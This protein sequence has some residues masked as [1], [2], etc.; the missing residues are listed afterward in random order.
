VALAQIG[1]FSFILANLGRELTFRGEPL[2][3]DAA[4]HTIIAAAIVSITIN[5]ALYRL[6]DA[7]EHRA[8]RSPRLWK[9]LSGRTSALTSQAG[10]EDQPENGGQ[11]IVV[12][13]GPVGRTLVRLL[14]ENDIQP[15]IIEMNLETVRRLRD[16]GLTAVYGDAT[17][18]ETLLAAGVERAVAVL[19]TSSGMHGSEE[20]IRIA[21]EMNPEIRVVARANYLREVPTL[22]KAGADAVFSGEGEVALTM[23]EFML[24]QLGATAE[25]ID[26]AGD[27]TRSELFGTP[28]TVELL[29]PLPGRHGPE[30]HSSTAGSPDDE[31]EQP[32]KSITNDQ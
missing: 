32:A 4:N 1:E 28:Q 25:Q 31:A 17:H 29:L 8:K 18:K 2:L 26:R 15:A 16:E 5:P 24:R 21:R 22:A 3:P 11:V 13:Y 20:A 7:M 14:L 27:R 30:E 12:G 23:T 6:I 19:L 9:L 10:R